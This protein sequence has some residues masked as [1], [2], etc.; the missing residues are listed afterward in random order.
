MGKPKQK[1]GSQEKSAAGLDLGPERVAHLLK[2]AD[3]A[4]AESKISVLRAAVAADPLD[5][6]GYHREII[7]KRGKIQM[8][9][10]SCVQEKLNLSK[11]DSM[12]KCWHPFGNTPSINL[13]KNHCGSDQSDQGAGPS[14]LC[15]ASGDL[16]HILYTCSQSNAKDSTTRFKDLYFFVNDIDPVVI[17]R[18]LLFVLLLDG[19]TFQ[20]STKDAVE[21]VAALWYSARISR[22]HL[23]QFK[24]ALDWLIEKM[25]VDLPFSFGSIELDAKSAASVRNILEYWQQL[26]PG[27]QPQWLEKSEDSCMKL[28]CCRLMG[29]WKPC[30][31]QYFRTKTLARCD[32]VKV[33]NLAWNPTMCH[34]KKAVIAGSVPFRCFFLQ[35]LTQDNRHAADSSH[36]I[37]LG[38]KMLEM[39][40]SMLAQALAGSKRSLFLFHSPSTFNT[41]ALH[42]KIFFPIIAICPLLNNKQGDL[43]SCIK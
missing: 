31:Q 29:R 19:S 28:D 22:E 16:R 27:S 9:L 11:E 1:A 30:V 24:A 26:P 43:S 5:T 13:L 12:N 15:V 3:T 33:G 14:V 6:L 39:V 8:S 36:Q 38:Q 2:A 35:D 34:P 25:V 37:C 32:K 41:L 10:W 42:R 18:N 4:P 17:A 20:H 40:H 21:L 23:S 7:S